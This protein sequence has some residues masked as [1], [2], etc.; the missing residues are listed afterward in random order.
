[1]ASDGAAKKK[2]IQV[3]LKVLFRLRKEKPDKN[4]NVKIATIDELK[5]SKFKDWFEVRNR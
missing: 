2:V 3:A 4:L 5:R 1:M